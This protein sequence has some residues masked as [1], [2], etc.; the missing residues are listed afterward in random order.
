MCLHIYILLQLTFKIHTKI[1]VTLLNIKILM[2]N[3]HV[4]KK[5][6]FIHLFISDCQINP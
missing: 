5:K 2:P 6:T 3:S 4:D 1:K